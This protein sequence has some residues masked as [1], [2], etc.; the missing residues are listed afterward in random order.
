VIVSKF[1]GYV[2]SIFGAKDLG[3]VVGGPENLHFL[4]GVRMVDVGVGVRG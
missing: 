3:I 2:Q 1:S 4:V